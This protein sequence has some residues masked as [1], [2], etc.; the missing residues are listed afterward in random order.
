MNSDN[1]QMVHL[2]IGGLHSKSTREHIYD[3][4]SEYGKV[5]DLDMTRILDPNQVHRGF[6]F[7]VLAQVNNI[8]KLIGE[9]HV[10]GRR[11]EIKFRTNE[12]IFL[13]NLPWDCTREMLVEAFDFYN[14]SLS[15]VFIG[16]GQNGMELGKGCVRI[17]V[18]GHKPRDFG[19]IALSRLG[20]IMVGSTVIIVKTDH[21]KRKN[22]KFEQSPY[23][24]GGPQ[25]EPNLQK[26][27]YRSRLSDEPKEEPKK[28]R[29]DVNR[30]QKGQL[31]KS[32]PYTRAVQQ[33]K[34][35]YDD[36]DE[37]ED[38]VDKPELEFPP[39]RMSKYSDSKS[40][41][42]GRN[43]IQ[44][45]AQLKISELNAEEILQETLAASLVDWDS[46]EDKSS[47][48]LKLSQENSGQYGDYERPGNTLQELLDAQE[49][50]VH[51]N[52]SLNP[53]EFASGSFLNPA[54]FTADDSALRKMDSHI[55]AE[56]AATNGGKLGLKE[57]LELRKKK[58]QALQK[59]PEAADTMGAALFNTDDQN[60]HH[61][62]PFSEVY[63]PN[64]MGIFS[65][66][67]VPQSAPFYI[68]N[69]GPSNTNWREATKSGKPLA[70]NPQS[71][72][73]FPSPQLESS[74]SGSWLK[75]RKTS[76]D[77]ELL[78]TNN[79]HPKMVTP[80]SHSVFPSATRQIIFPF[81]AF[82][83]YG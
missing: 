60:K 15:E 57:K 19:A 5:V 3:L 70:L 77:Q 83:G 75:D 41:D 71:P 62:S 39:K 45:P 78:Q 1:S 63:F 55:T 4:L 27:L 73:I 82:P 46:G 36:Y 80:D 13:E 79:L 9:H 49:T 25:P 34:A 30:Y 18:A 28:G 6:A 56:T 66:R 37:E 21:I 40:S 50:F 23:Y 33:P 48:F 52:S 67:P 76:N 43:Q 58:Q 59:Q 44:P 64:Q 61:L 7:A 2:F 16:N 81:Y 24:E 35:S 17:K 8:K 69:N 26:N 42:R 38:S 31:E 10:N 74:A 51:H 32:K 65:V 47:Q 22:S 11:I 54:N 72:P 29:S 12:K 53:S 14:I 68:E 20:P